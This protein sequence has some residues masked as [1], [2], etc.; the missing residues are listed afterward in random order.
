M[1]DVLVKGPACTFC[2]KARCPQP[3]PNPALASPPHSTARNEDGVPFSLRSSSGAWPCWTLASSSAVHVEDNSCAVKRVEGTEEC[4]ALSLPPSP[5]IACLA[6]IA[7]DSGLPSVAI[8]VPSVT[9]CPGD[10]VDC[11]RAGLTGPEAA[12]VA[13]REGLWRAATSGLTW[14]AAPFAV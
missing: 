8:S 11:T 12:A 6:R 1:S 13:H 7:L 2:V 4:R 10:R 5:R 9:L 3:H 14:V